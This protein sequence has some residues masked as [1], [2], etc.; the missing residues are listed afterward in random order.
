[1]N[2]LDQRIMRNLRTE[3]RLS[4]RRAEYV[5]PERTEKWAAA[6]RL[7][8]EEEKKIWDA[9][10]AVKTEKEC[11][12]IRQRLSSY[13]PEWETWAKS[14]YKDQGDKLVST[15]REWKEEVA[16]TI[17]SELAKLKKIEKLVKYK[18][19]DRMRGRGNVEEDISKE[20]LV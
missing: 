1:M 8:I 4:V 9:E 2:E 14:L 19:R 15:A 18:I 16:W 10:V 20:R 6:R 11:E 17:D 12:K 13:D 3:A 5:L 7:I